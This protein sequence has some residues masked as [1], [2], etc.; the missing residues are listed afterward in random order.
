MSTL[1]LLHP[2]DLTPDKAQALVQNALHKADDGDLFL[3]S[4]KSQTL[5]LEDGHIKTASYSDGAGFGLRRIDGANSAL[6]HSSILQ[7]NRLEDAAK[8]LAALAGDAVT[9]PMDGPTAHTHSLYQPLNVV[10]EIETA[11]YITL[12]QNIDLYLRQKSSM[13]TQ[14]MAS[15]SLETREILII[16]PEGPVVGDVQ[17]LVRL[18]ISVMVT[19]KNG[20][21]EIAREGFGGRYSATALLNEKKWQTLADTTLQKAKVQLEAIPAP[22]GEMPVI[23]ANGWSGVLFHEAV[24]HGLEGDFNRRGTSTFSGRIGEKVAPENVTVI[25]DGT[26]AERRGSLNVDDEGTPTACNVL[27]ENGVLKKYMQDRTNARLMGVAPTGNGRRESYAC[28][29]MP[30]MTNT[31]LAAGEDTKEDMLKGISKGLYCESFGGGQVDIVSGNYVFEVS[32]AYLIEN[33]QKTRPV[34]GATL[35]GHGPTSLKYIDKVGSDLEL[36]PGVG[37]CG[38]DGQSVPAG[39]GMPTIRLMGGLT[40]GGMSD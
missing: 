21:R 35:I 19:D 37:T 8:Q 30:R 20:R 33:G 10:D 14:V 15:L 40:V 38:K 2:F 31:F 28:N 17:P 22:G 18:N 39:V 7:K 16:R 5:H 9:V 29:V 25:D 24:G 13:V 11:A 34:K 26:M 4:T 3:E 27:I 1:H 23:M 6:V 36:D 32:E 12:L